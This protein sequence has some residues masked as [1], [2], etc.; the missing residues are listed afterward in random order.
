MENAQYSRLESLEIIS[1]PASIENDELE[2]RVCQTFVKLGVSIGDTGIQASYRF[3]PLII[4][5]YN[6]VFKQLDP[7]V[8]DLLEVIA[9]LVNDSPCPLYHGLSNIC[10]KLKGPN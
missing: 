2:R 6:H 10:G 8:L 9:V 1:K 4:Q 5:D 3:N 7:I